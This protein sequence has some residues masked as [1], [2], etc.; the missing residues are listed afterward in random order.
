VSIHAELKKLLER[1]AN[2]EQ[3]EIHL[4]SVDWA[5]IRTMGNPPQMRIKT[6]TVETGSMHD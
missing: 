3:V 5:V 2:E 1:I 6:I 4:I